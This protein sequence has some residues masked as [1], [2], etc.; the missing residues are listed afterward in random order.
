[1]SR[2]RRGLDIAAPGL[3]FLALLLA[4][5]GAARFF[6]LPSYLLPAPS[7]IWEA[8]RQVDASIWLQHIWATTRVAIIGYALSIAISLPLAIALSMSRLMSR[9]L[10]PLL[11]LVQSTPIVAVAP[12]IVVALGAGDLPRVVITMMIAFFPL[13]VTTA[14]GLL[15][16]PEELIEL[17]RS[18]S[19]PRHREIIQIRLMFA[20]PYIFSA[21][22]ISITLAVIGAVVAEFV[23]AENG[24]GY[25]ILYSTSFFKVPQA[26]AALA[27]LVAISLLLFQ[28]VSLIQRLLFPWSL[29]PTK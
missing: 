24:L 3:F 16:T 29:T 28:S 9:T 20:V 6:A 21:L 18:L 7:A 23:A 25:F 8:G 2:L 12:I 26:F 27:V 11:V 14:T 15:A 10:Y 17:S 22:K 19:A 4:W 13:V 5:E 1:M